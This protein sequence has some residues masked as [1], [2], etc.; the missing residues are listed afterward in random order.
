MAAVGKGRGPEIKEL[1]VASTARLRGGMPRARD[2]HVKILSIHVPWTDLNNLF[3]KTDVP[4]RMCVRVCACPCVRVCL[5]ARSRL[6]A[7]HTVPCELRFHLE[8]QCLQDHLPGGKLALGVRQGAGVW[9]VLLN[10][11]PP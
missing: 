7:P 5:C 4:G 2:S 11:R 1:A 8:M 9:L 10:L 3:V 6:F